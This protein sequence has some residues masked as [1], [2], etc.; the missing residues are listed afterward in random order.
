MRAASTRRAS[1]SEGM[2]IASA[3]GRNS[4]RGG[5]LHPA[6]H[7]RSPKSRGSRMGAP[8][9]AWPHH[10]PAEGSRIIHTVTDLAFVMAPRQNQFFVELVGALRHELKAIGVN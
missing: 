6:I 9:A 10:S 4:C 8:P 7:I 5:L 2:A 1:R 3:S